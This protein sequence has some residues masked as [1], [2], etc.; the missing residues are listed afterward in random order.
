MFNFFLLIAVAYMIKGCK[1]E[2]SDLED[3]DEFA[4]FQQT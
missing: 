4:L 1:D 2:N 3:S